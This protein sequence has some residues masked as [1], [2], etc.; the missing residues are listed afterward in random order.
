MKIKPHIIVLLAVLLVAG[1]IVSPVSAGKYT[2]TNMPLYDKT[3]VDYKGVYNMSHDAAKDGLRIALIQFTIPTESRVDFTI[4]YGNDSSVSGYSENH[5][6]FDAW[7]VSRTVSTVNL[8]GVSKEYTFIDTQPFYD[9][10]LAGYARDRDWLDLLNTTA[11][12]GF[13]VYSLNYGGL[14][15]DLAVFYEVPNPTIDTIYRIDASCSKPFDMFVT[16]GSPADVSKGAGVDPLLA[17]INEGSRWINYVLTLSSFVWG[18]VTG[19]FGWIKFFFI[20]NLVMTISIYL[21]I[22]MA[23]S[24]ATSRNIFQF[25]QRFFKYQRSL[26]EFIIGLW[27]VL[28]EIISSFR[29]IF[30]I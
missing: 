6:T 16:M 22:T 5:K 23:V 24:A 21:A 1:M 9:F 26:F 3:N 2:L 29:G 17:A 10:N 11:P 13:L 25:F 12:A 4:Y 28:F 7:L 30:R 14:D 19:L 15:N 20:D 18:F 8:N 27:R